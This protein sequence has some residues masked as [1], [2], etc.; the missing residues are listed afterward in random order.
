MNRRHVFYQ[1]LYWIFVFV[2]LMVALWFFQSMPPMIEATSGIYFSTGRVQIWILPTANALFGLLFFP[3]SRK[4]AQDLEQN[5]REQGKSTDIL[6]VLSG[7]QLYVML[8]LSALTLAALY[9]HTAFDGG[10]SIQNFTSSVLVFA[11]GA[12][13]SLFAWR[14]PHA[15]QSS[16]LALHF[17]YTHK[18]QKIWG[19]THALAAKV[20]YAVGAILMLA[21]FM[22]SGWILIFFAVF[23]PAFSLW[24]IYHYAKHLYESDFH[25]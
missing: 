5:Q 17:S 18:C 25:K 10:A 11:L 15:A 24:A 16:F 14:L 3:F 1:F 23:A 13:L 21:A 19:K 4:M 9:G 12:G 20:L 7:I 22:L 6:Q 8:S 2:P